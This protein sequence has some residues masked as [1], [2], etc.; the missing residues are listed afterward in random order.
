MKRIDPTLKIITLQNE[1]IDTTDQFPS[2][3]SEYTSKFKE[4]NKDTKS[5]RV[6]V[7]HTVITLGEIN[8]AI[9]NKFQAFSIL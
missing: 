5:S 6:Y 2:S 7:S 4:M 9:N 8:T 3:A 1:T